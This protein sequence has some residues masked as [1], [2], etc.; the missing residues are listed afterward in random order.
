M[1]RTHIAGSLTFPFQRNGTVGGSVE[2]VGYGVRR[3]QARHLLLCAL[4]AFQGSSLDGESV[5]GLGEEL[6]ELD[7][8]INRLRH[9]QAMAVARFDSRGGA[10]ADGLPTTATHGEAGALVPT[11][12]DPRDRLPNTAAALRC[13]ELGWDGAQTIARGCARCTTRRCSGRRT[14]S[15]P[16]TPRAGPSTS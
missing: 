12:R 1:I 14:R 2:Y 11:G 16:R 3:S 8:A 6:V 9:A 15:S 5:A 7:A 10:A 4:D 13:G